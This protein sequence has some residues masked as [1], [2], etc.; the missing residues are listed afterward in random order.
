MFKSKLVKIITPFLLLFDNDIIILCVEM[1]LNDKEY[2]I[3]T[4]RI[5]FKTDWKQALEW[6]KA[7][8]FDISQ[9]TYFRTLAVVDKEVTERLFKIAKEFEVIASEEIIKF[10]NLEK[11]MYEEY[12]KED[13]PLNRA[14]ILQMIANLQPYIT[15][16]YDQTRLV[17]EGKLNAEKD[18]ILSKHPE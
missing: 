11:Q 17:L 15:A 2:H 18:N 1:T 16:L 8:G 3:V 14:R 9:A 12:H 10:N 6:L 13:Q 7:R 5:M 4:A